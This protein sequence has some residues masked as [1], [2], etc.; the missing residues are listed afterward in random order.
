MPRCGRR[1]RRFIH[2]RRHRDVVSVRYSHLDSPK[3][4]LADF[5]PTLQAEESPSGSAFPADFS[6]PSARSLRRRSIH[7]LFCSSL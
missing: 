2:Q 7:Q 3:T 6:R 4:G 5:Q 1:L